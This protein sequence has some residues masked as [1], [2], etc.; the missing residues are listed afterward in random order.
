MTSHQEQKTAVAA[1]LPPPPGSAVSWRPRT[2]P[3]TG[4]LIALPKTSV[5]H[6]STLAIRSGKPCNLPL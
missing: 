5:E 2:I 3:R 6:L 1:A 4:V